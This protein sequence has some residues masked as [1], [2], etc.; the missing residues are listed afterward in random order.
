MS[1]SLLAERLLNV[2]IRSRSVIDDG[3]IGIV[4]KYIGTQASGKVQVDS[5]GNLI[6]I[7]G[8]VGSEAADTTIGAPTLNGTITVSDASADTFGEVLDIIN[9]SANW[10]AYL[11]DALRTDSSNASTGSLL[12]MSSTQANVAGGIALNKD[13][14]KVLNMSIALR[15]LVYPNNTFGKDDSKR[16][17]SSLEVGRW[18]EALRHVS[19]NTFGSGTSLIQIHKVDRLTGTATKIWERAGGATT[20]EQDKDVSDGFGRGIACDPDQYLLVRLI[21]SVAC[22]GTLAVSGKVV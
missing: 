10:V 15:Y 3:D 1:D 18:S 20:V 4:V 21:G 7:H 9:A 2:R 14:S 12:V 22:T 11:V 8:A 5:S 17:V 16:T 6:F 19:T 13:T